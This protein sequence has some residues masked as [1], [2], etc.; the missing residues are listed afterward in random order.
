[1]RQIVLTKG[2]PASGKTTWAKEQIKLH[3]GRFKRVNRDLMRLMLDDNP[4]VTFKNKD[5]VFINDARDLIVERAITAGYD[6]I[7]DDTNLSNDTFKQMCDIAKR[8]GD[9]EVKEKYFKISPELALQ[10]NATRLSQVP[11]EVIYRMYNNYI[12]DKEIVEKCEFFAK[13]K[14]NFAKDFSKD[15]AIIVDIDG[16]L[17]HAYTRY[18]HDESKVNEDTIDEDIR[19]LVNKLSNEFKVIITSGRKETCRAETKKWL[20]KNKV[21]FDKLLMRKS[22]DN[23]KDSIVKKEIY[24]NDIFPKNCVYYVIDDRPSVVKMWRSLGLTVLQVNDINF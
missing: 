8:I 10:R 16:T 14:K 24:D 5:E 22:D 4:N 7:L 21:V 11:E 20:T 2:I 1:M 15:A 13:S 3:P 17:A 19:G 6:I 12:K 9:V 23:R 18:I